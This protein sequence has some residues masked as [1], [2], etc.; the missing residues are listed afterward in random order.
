MHNLQFA[1]AICCIEF[2][3]ISMNS[4]SK[5]EVKLRT[6]KIYPRLCKLTTDRLDLSADKNFYRTTQK[7]ST[8]VSLGAYDETLQRRVLINIVGQTELFVAPI[9]RPMNLPV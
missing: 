6:N 9:Y 5:A 7:T 1:H 2:V 4:E 8:D 3:P